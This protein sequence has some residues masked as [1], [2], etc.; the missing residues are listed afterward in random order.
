MNLYGNSSHPASNK[1]LF[2]TYSSFVGLKAQPTC[3]M[4]DFT[5]PAAFIMSALNCYTF[6]C[7]SKP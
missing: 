1:Y 2:I 7:A 3:L 5:Q 4:L 6:V